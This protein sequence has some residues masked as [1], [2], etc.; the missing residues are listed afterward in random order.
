ML[1]NIYVDI[2]RFCRVVLQL[3]TDGHFDI[4]YC[5]M[6][7]ISENIKEVSKVAIYIM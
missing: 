4:E 7:G 5:D 3:E 6:C 2:Y 1:N